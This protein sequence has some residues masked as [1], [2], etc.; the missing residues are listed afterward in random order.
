MQAGNGYSVEIR[1]TWHCG[2]TFNITGAASPLSQ[3]ETLETLAGV[4]REKRRRRK[5]VFGRHR[6]LAYLVAQALVKSP[7]S[8]RRLTTN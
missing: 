2:Q 4:Y 8:V 3:G 6:R 7:F 1:S 5:A